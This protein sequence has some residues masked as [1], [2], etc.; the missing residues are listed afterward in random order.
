[1]KKKHGHFLAAM[2]ADVRQT[3]VLSLLFCILS[4]FASPV[5]A[6]H[7]SEVEKKAILTAQY[8]NEAPK[9]SIKYGLEALELLKSIPR[10]DIEVRVLNDLCWSYRNLGNFQKSLDCGY[11]SVT[12]AAKIN[13]YKGL[14]I[15][16]KNLGVLHIQFYK[17][18]Q[19][20]LHYTKAL[21]IFRQLGDD[22]EIAN[23]LNNLGIVHESISAHDKTL[24]YY[25]QALELYTRLNNKDG[26]T[27]VL[28]NI[29][30]VYLSLTRYRD[31]LKYYE[32]SLA[33]S[34][35]LNNDLG[36]ADVLANIGVVNYYLGDYPK[37]MIHYEQA[38][39]LFRRKQNKIST[40]NMLNNICELLLKQKNYRE[41]QKYCYQAIDI[42]RQAG[43]AWELANSLNN[44]GNI[45]FNCNE[46]E[47]A[48]EH[49][50]HAR[51]LAEEIKAKDLV[52]NSFQ[53]LSAI[54]EK[55]RDYKV[56]LEYHR[57]YKNM[58]DRI[59][60]E[61][62][63]KKIAEMQIKYKTD[64][65]ENEIE[66]LKRDQEIQKLELDK[67][68]NI[69]YSLL[70][71]IFLAFALG[72]FLY[73]RF[74]IKTRIAK[75]LQK[76]IAEHERTH[77]KLRESEEKFRSLA[78]KSMVG[79][80]IIQDNTFK[81]INPQFARLLG[82]P[83][84]EL[85]DI[86]SLPD[87]VT[88]DSQDDIR[89]SLE[90]RLSGKSQSLRWEMRIINKNGDTVFLEAFDSVTLFNGRPA[91]MGSVIDITDHKRAEKEQL[92]RR[93]MEAISILAAGI[94]H[95][96]N[97]LLISI[98]SSLNLLKIKF[99][100]GK[101]DPETISAFDN[102]DK[103]SSQALDLA[104]KLITFC[105]G[106][107]M[108]REKLNLDYLLKTAIDFSPD[109]NGHPIHAT[110]PENLLPIYVDER[111]FR[112]VLQNLLINAAAATPDKQPIQVDAEN[113]TLAEPAASAANTP[114]PGRVYVKIR[115][116]DKGCGIPGDQLENIFDPH[117]GPKNTAEQT[118]LGLGLAISYSIVKK[119]DGHITLESQPGQGT[120]VYLYMPACTGDTA[121]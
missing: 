80:Y 83:P 28:N 77:L 22:L 74:Q 47:K 51:R 79:I 86:K 29:G 3:V 56:A 81:Y 37:A 2:I 69:K 73:N 20:L 49:V 116:R 110:F 4:L 44:L 23:T 6:A 87:L 54:Y 1:M 55:R 48:V 61:K 89:Q 66:L 60:D 113:F 118:N 14:A 98:I 62:D 111:Q 32:K 96:F 71:I 34:R 41:A 82:Y 24:E 103:S 27:K 25:F 114:I 102:L 76:E 42:Y 104:Q 72:L 12:L 97:N 19:S 13:D 106:G 107:W 15:A 105:S 59:F 5:A 92:K 108:K 100:R 121:H 43:V 95:D 65:K 50:N 21:D 38:L 117:Y 120:D 99:K 93:K 7:V 9:E 39:E 68:R 70:F 17:Q 75:N 109:L 91:V 63:K 88:P 90:N 36:A 94:A 119:H 84:E 52:K 78:E 10:T 30:S 33:L 85:L 40:G 35:E 57:L 115:I 64:S 112:Q 58:H 11:R 45:E 53:I 16:H 67:H 18:N 101:K 8:R 31:A 46:P 26:A